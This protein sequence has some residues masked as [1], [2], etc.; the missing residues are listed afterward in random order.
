ML[1]LT[2]SKAPVSKNETAE[3]VTHSAAKHLLSSI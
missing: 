3:N 1:S 2:S